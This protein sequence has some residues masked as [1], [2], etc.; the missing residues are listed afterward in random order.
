MHSHKETP[1]SGGAYRYA[2]VTNT[3]PWSDVPF[4]PIRFT[5]IAPVGEMFWVPFCDKSQVSA[6]TIVFEAK[7]GGPMD[8]FVGQV[9]SGQGAV[10]TAKDVIRD[11][12]PWA[13]EHVKEAMLSDEL[14]PLTGNCNPQ[15]GNQLADSRLEKRLWP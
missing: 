5:F 11:L 14:V 2:P 10:Q 13:Y 7:S 3:K 8:R 1:S 4:H 12:M 9:K 6:Y 15:C